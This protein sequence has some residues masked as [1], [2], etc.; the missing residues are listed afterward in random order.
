MAV[1]P[2]FGILHHRHFLKTQS[3]GL[4]SYVHIWWGRILMVLGV[5]N[6]GLGL[7][8]SSEGNGLVIA[9]SVVAGL[10]FLCYIGY[11][12]CGLFRGGT[13]PVVGRGSAKGRQRSVYRS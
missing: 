7:K 4:I 10:A 12:A 5:I 13:K 6:G 1:Q 2:V 11:K 9:Y 3:R 8:L